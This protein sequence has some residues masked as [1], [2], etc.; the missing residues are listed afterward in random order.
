MFNMLEMSISGYQRVPDFH[1]KCGYP[2][3]VSRDFGVPLN[4]E[5]NKYW[6]LSMPDILSSTTTSI[7][8]GMNYP[9]RRGGVL[10]LI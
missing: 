6:K 5:I 4:V 2:D 1:T 8:G 7:A 3:T 9:A 10:S